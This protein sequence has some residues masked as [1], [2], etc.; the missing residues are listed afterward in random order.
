MFKKHG[1][2]IEFSTTRF[3]VVD[4]SSRPA[5]F[6]K[7][8]HALCFVQPP[9]WLPLGLWLRL[10]SRLRLL[11]GRESLVLPT[12]SETD[13]IDGSYEPW[14]HNPISASRMRPILPKEKPPGST[15]AIRKEE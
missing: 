3:W 13:E 2:L 7:Y 14:V 5:Y 10:P 9:R 15:G 11:T 4:S 1:K 12:P 6:A 8:T